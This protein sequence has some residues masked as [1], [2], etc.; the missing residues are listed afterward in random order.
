MVDPCI[1]D[2]PAASRQYSHLAFEVG[3][4]GVGLQCRVE[5]WPP[6]VT[7]AGLV[8]LGEVRLSCTASTHCHCISSKLPPLFVE[9]V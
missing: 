7:V 9:Q 5:V 3:L 6:A 8:Q 4:E 1:S 2:D